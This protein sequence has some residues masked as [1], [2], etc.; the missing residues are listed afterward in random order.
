[1]ETVQVI[2]DSNPLYFYIYI[3]HSSCLHCIDS[4]V[5]YVY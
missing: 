1:M 5:C 3:Q 2:D 4:G